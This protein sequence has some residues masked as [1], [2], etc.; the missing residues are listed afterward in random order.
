MKWGISLGLTLNLTQILLLVM[1]S[2][3]RDTA[4]TQTTVFKALLRDRRQMHGVLRRSALTGNRSRLHCTVACLREP[5]CVALNIRR[6]RGV[7]ELLSA[8]GQ[9]KQLMDEMGSEFLVNTRKIRT[10][11]D[12]PCQNGGSCVD[13]P[14]G[15]LGRLQAYT[16]R[17]PCG[18][19][20][21]HCED[22]NYWLQEHSG[23]RGHNIPHNAL[24]VD[25]LEACLKICLS[26]PGCRSVDYTNNDNSCNLNNVTH[27]VAHLKRIED[28]TYVAPLCRCGHGEGPASPGKPP[29]TPV[30]N[31]D[32]GAPS[33]R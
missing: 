8:I 17:C 24:Y 12:G 23:I 13:V 9:L 28:V 15:T 32:D 7:C 11:A 22:M 1:L 30:R 14:R 3:C 18:F 31:A 4:T 10:C 6:K 29:V 19:C 2:G 20:G 25:T 21:L 5:Q 16:C 26:V 27:E 33:P